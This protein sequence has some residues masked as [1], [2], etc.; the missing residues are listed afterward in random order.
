MNTRTTIALTL[1]VLMVHFAQADEKVSP[2]VAPH[3]KLAVQP[4]THIALHRDGMLVG[5]VV[6][7]QTLGQAGETVVVKFQ[8]HTVATAKTK[9]NGQFVI[10]GLKPGLH[11][12]ESANSVASYQFW[13]AQTAPPAARPAVLVV[14]DQG[15]VRGQLGDGDPVTGAIIVGSAAGGLVTYAIVTEGS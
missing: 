14:G 1:S 8:G 11:Q 5:Q 12:I 6:N 4:V 3:T 13:A 2:K 7:S 9:S 10:R 15:V